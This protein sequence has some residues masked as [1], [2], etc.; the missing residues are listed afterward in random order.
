M[1]GIVTATDLDTARELAHECNN[2]AY[3]WKLTYHEA[4]TRQAGW[5][6]E[7]ACVS[8]LLTRANAAIRFEVAERLKR[9]RGERP[10]IEFGKRIFSTGHEAAVACVDT[11]LGC[12]KLADE[13]LTR[14]GWRSPYQSKV[15]ITGWLQNDGSV[16][17]WTWN[18]DELAERIDAEWSL[19]LKGLEAVRA[20]AADDPQ[21]ALKTEGAVSQGVFVYNGNRVEN[22]PPA[23]W[24][25]L[26]FMESKSEADSEEAYRYAIKDHAKESTSSAIK[27]LLTKANA[28]LEEVTY[29]KNLSKVRGLEKLIWS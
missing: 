28:A 10:K 12:L 15:H 2:R 23:P 26:E 19:A 1:G 5:K 4:A 11:I 22:I 13:C 17:D 7:I 29:P 21:K 14:P 8:E 3:I 18:H 6:E 25:L 24:R 27:S 20:G 9:Y 16:A